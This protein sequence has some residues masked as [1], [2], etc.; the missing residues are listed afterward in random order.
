[1]NAKKCTT[2]RMTRKKSPLVGEFYIEGQPLESV[3]VH[4]VWDCLLLGLF[5]AGDLISRNQHR[6]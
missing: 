3:N 1:M 2:M 4:K 5:T 6:D